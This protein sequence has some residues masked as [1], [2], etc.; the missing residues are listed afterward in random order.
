MVGLVYY[1]WVWWWLDWFIIAEYGGGWTGLELLSMVVVG[2]VVIAE[3]GVV[4]IGLV[5]ITEDG[6]GWTGCYH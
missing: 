2:L 5:V 1:C 3:H 6:D 4:M